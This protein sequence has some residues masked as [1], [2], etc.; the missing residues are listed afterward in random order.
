MLKEWKNKRQL[1]LLIAFALSAG[2]GQL[3]FNHAHAA[4]VTGGNVTYDTTLPADPI[5]GG[6]I[7]PSTTDPGN[8]HHNTLTINGLDVNGRNF[9]G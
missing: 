3:F 1:S 8:V 4:D 6:A 7:S 2:V 9:Y 5:A